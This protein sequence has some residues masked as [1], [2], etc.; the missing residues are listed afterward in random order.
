M[1][2][3]NTHVRTSDRKRRKNDRDEELERA[4]DIADYLV[5]GG[6]EDVELM[7]R[8]LY[9]SDDEALKA[10]IENDCDRTAAMIMLVEED[11][12]RLRLINRTI[13]PSQHMLE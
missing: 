3:L 10:L 6:Y 7:C 4:I 1:K 5:H 2:R 13:E 9:I 8:C 12:S 11:E